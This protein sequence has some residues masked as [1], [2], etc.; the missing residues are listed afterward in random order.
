VSPSR[1]GIGR[2]PT[3]RPTPAGVARLSAPRPVRSPRRS[4]HRCRGEAPV[5]PS[6][7]RA[8]RARRPR[9]S[10]GA[11]RGGREGAPVG[12]EVQVPAVMRCLYACRRSP[13]ASSSSHHPHEPAGQLLA[14]EIEQRLPDR[15]LVLD[16]RCV[17]VHD[18]SVVADLRQNNNMAPSTLTCC[19]SRRGGRKQ[20]TCLSPGT[21]SGF[22][23]WEHKFVAPRR[24]SGRDR[25]ASLG[26]RWLS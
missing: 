26:Y 10:A 22:P 23:G 14:H 9:R 19:A 16:E 15:L 8:P 1:R 17:G 20:P 18:R 12:G 4:A 13:L 3:A 6:G 7:P 2:E 11:G 5:P 24:Q 21:F 25:R